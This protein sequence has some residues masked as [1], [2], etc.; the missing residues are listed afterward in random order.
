MSWRDT[1]QQGDLD[2]AKFLTERSEMTPGRKIAVYDSPFGPGEV[3]SIDLGKRPLKFVLDAIFLGDNYQ[4][5]RNKFLKVINAPGPKPLTHPYYGSIYVIPDPEA[6][7]SVLEDMNEEGGLARVKLT[8][9]RH[10]APSTTAK[11]P[12]L[13]I[14]SA[15]AMAAAST[16]LGDALAADFADGLSVDDIVQAANIDALDDILSDLQSLNGDIDA[17]LSVPGNFASQ[18]TDIIGELQELVSTPD[19]LFS[20]ID[21]MMEKIGASVAQLGQQVQKSSAAET[22][23]V[24]ARTAALGNATE[25]QDI[26]DVNTPTR[27]AQRENKAKILLNL[28]ANASRRMADGVA[29]NPP[30]NARDARK[31]AR[32]VRAAI[33]DTLE[34]SLHG[35]EL[36]ANTRRA[37]TRY[38]TAAVAYLERQA[39]TLTEVQEWTPPETLPAEVV[40]WIVHGDARRA[41]DVA[42]RARA[43]HPGMLPAGVPIEL[44][45]R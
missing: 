4:E 21:G 8:L 20:S 43:E 14:G 40:A 37:L 45:V 44:L 5:D 24:I 33:T 42:N 12:S 13:G 32:A 1:L 9:I 34:K 28:R 10:Q 38:R 6:L 25:S 39:G 17:L 26:P 15:A 19:K 27:N 22:S 29:A 18:I 11:A 16:D 35:K 31:N 2:G 23:S 30:D 36:T 41:E 7:M 3:S